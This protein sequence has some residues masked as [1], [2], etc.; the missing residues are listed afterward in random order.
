MS[1]TF[2]QKLADLKKNGKEEVKTKKESTKKKVD[3]TVK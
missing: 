2:F 1:K 3:K